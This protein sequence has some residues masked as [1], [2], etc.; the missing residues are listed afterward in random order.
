MVRNTEANERVQA[1]KEIEVY[2]YTRI[3]NYLLDETVENLKALTEKYYADIN[4]EKKMNYDG[5]PERDS[6]DKILYNLQS[7]NKA[8]IDV[9]TT[10]TVREIAMQKLN[11]KY[12]RFLPEDKPN[13]ALMY[14]NARSS[15]SQLDLHIDSHIP[16]RGPY[17]TNMQFAFA[18]EDST[19]ENG[20]TVVVPGSHQSGEYTDRELQ[21]LKHVT[22]KAG[23]ML[24]WDSR[25]WHGTTPNKSDK[26]RW[27]LIATLGMWW[28]KPSMDI[29]RSLPNEIY[30]ELN[31][32]QKALMGFCSIPPHDEFERNN[33]KCGYDFLKE[34]VSDYFRKN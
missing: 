14:Y 11:D 27:I 22:A 31:D 4:K 32:E 30:Q 2:G 19:I 17:T 18:L 20:C 16:F 5:V 15:G 10:D 12:Y 25:V 24:C 8:F 1:L 3:E 28:L 26:S 29:T 21:N 23:D 13:Y 9:L 33:T 34:N 6:S 7:K